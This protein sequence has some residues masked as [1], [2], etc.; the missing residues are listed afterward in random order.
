MKYLTRNICSCDDCDAIDYLLAQQPIC[1]VG[2]EKV[3]FEFPYFSL[4]MDE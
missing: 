1:E 4:F 2:F 3:S